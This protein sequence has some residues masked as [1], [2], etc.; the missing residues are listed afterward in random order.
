[1][2]CL[3]LNHKTSECKLHVTCNKCNKNHNTL[4]HLDAYKRNEKDSYTK[5]KSMPGTSAAA[6]TKQTVQSMT[7]SNNN[8]VLLATTI[9]NVQAL[10]GAPIMLRALI[11]QGS[12]S[13]YITENAAQMLAL[14]RTKISATITGIGNQTK[15]TNHS[16][17]LTVTPRTASNF[18]LRANAIVLEKLSSNSDIEY[19][20]GE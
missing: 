2:N 20:Q 14:P 3:H 11:D 18:I 19:T 5:S 10:H 15:H 13:A 6:T 17:Q 1:M 16:V 8:N 4:L 9:I 12:Q 7:A